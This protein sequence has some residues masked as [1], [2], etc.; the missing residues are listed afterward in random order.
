MSRFG[1]EV[2]NQLGWCDGCNRTVGDSD[3]GKHNPGQNWGDTHGGDRHGVRHR[4][5][6][7]HGDGNDGTG[8]R[9]GDTHGDG[10]LV[11]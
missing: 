9:A 10:T 4:G 7:I 5:D 8:K 11:L 6:Y 3:H 2:R 1:G